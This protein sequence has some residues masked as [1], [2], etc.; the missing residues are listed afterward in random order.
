MGRSQLE[1]SAERSR[2]PQAVKKETMNQVATERPDAKAASCP[3]SP[4]TSK[5]RVA[6]GQGGGCLLLGLDDDALLRVASAVANA[7]ALARLALTCR[8]LGMK[9]PGRRFRLGGANA[10]VKGIAPPCA[11]EEQEELSLVEEAGRRWVANLDERERRWVPRREADT[12][13]RL[14]MEVEALRR[15]LVFGRSSSEIVLSE[16][17]ALATRSA[18]GKHTGRTAVS[19]RTMRAGCHFA[20]LV[21]NGML[22]G[23]GIFR[24]WMDVENGK[25]LFNV[26]GN[27]VLHTASGR[28]FPGFRAW[29]GLCMMKAGD[30]IG[31]LLDLD[32][33]S[34]TAYKNGERMGIMVAEGLSGEYCWGVSLCLPHVSARIKSLPAPPPPTQEEL[35]AA[36]TWQSK[37]AAKEM[38]AVAVR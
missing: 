21:L 22:L 37:T 11:E 31:L 8:R 30:R 1:R 25:D 12:W 24:P 6:C 16:G 13:L 18:V 10:C 33:G 27:C 9:L 4:G 26:E 32:R 2:K 19:T 15:P 36:A 34:L 35:L 20:E 5:V 14:R 17:G 28:V 38:A 3:A 29:P 7:S 23:F